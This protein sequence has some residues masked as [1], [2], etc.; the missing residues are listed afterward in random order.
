MFPVFPCF[1]RVEFLFLA[2]ILLI[3]IPDERPGANPA[4]LVQYSNSCFQSAKWAAL[5]SGPIAA[6]TPI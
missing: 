6:T 4:N 5:A 1:A 3:G 2:R